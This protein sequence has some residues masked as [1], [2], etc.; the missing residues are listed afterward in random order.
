MQNIVKSN[1][2]AY[3]KSPE[4]LSKEW[5]RCFIRQCSAAGHI[6]RLVKPATFGAATSIQGFTVYISVIA[7]TITN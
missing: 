4:G 1:P 5:W 6:T 7:L 2:S 3:G